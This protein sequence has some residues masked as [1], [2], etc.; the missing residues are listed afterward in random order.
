[1]QSARVGRLISD[2]ASRIPFGHFFEQ[3][4]ATNLSKVDCQE[5]SMVHEQKTATDIPA[6]TTI[7]PHSS[8]ATVDK[9]T[10]SAR[11]FASGSAFRERYRRRHDR[12]LA[13]PRH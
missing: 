12:L 10:S 11:Q 6:A 13:A 7:V 4:S 5:T 3:R 2:S 8:Q 9:A 1:M